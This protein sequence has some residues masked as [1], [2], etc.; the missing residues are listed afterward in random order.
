MNAEDR[1]GL[2]ESG[3][4][5]VVVARLMEGF[6]LFPKFHHAFA[7]LVRKLGVRK[8]RVY[9]GHHR[10]TTMSQGRARRKGKKD[11]RGQD[12]A[13]HVSAYAGYGRLAS[14]GITGAIR[15]TVYRMEPV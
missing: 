10:G 12:D 13:A 5:G 9:L 3:L 15:L 7:V 8:S 6:A 4:G 1:H 11:G 2:G 14:R